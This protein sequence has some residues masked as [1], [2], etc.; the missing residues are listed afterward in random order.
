MPT[1]TR[2]YANPQDWANHPLSNHLENGIH[3]CASS[4]MRAGIRIAYPNYTNLCSIN[5][6]MKKLYPDWN[7]SELQL[8]QFLKLSN[9]LQKN[10]TLFPSDELYGA[11]LSNKKG[12]VM[13][14]RKLAE[15]GVH[16]QDLEKTFQDMLFRGQ[17][18]SS[19]ERIFLTIWKA[20][21]QTIQNTSMNYA[22]YRNRLTSNH[23]T[24]ELLHKA[25]EEIQYSNPKKVNDKTV[26]FLHGF[27]FIT[28]EQQFFLKN[29]AEN[30]N[31]V[32]FLYYE[33]QY[34]RTF[35]FMRS[36][37]QPE[38]GWESIAKSN[39]ISDY[40]ANH[41]SD[42]FLRVYENDRGQFQPGTQEVLAYENF[43]EFMQHV[44][45][46]NY[47]EG[48]LETDNKSF[49]IFTP[50]ASQMNELLEN[51]YP[52]LNLK[53]RNFLSYPVG[54]F[55]STI[56][57]IYKDGEYE[58]SYDQLHELFASGWLYH[59]NLNARNFT[60]DLKN[61]QS[62]VERATTLDEWIRLSEQ[63]KKQISFIDQQFPL[64][65]D[66]SRMQ[67][68]TR[69]P[70]LKNSH[71]SI[72]VDRLNTIIQFLYDIKTI[73][74]ELFESGKDGTKIN[75]HF[76]RLERIMNDRIKRV[77]KS[78]DDVEKKLVQDLRAR[79]SMIQSNTDFLYND[80]YEAV[81]LYLSGKFDQKQEKLIRPFLEIDGEAFKHVAVS[82]NYKVYVGGLDEH[83]FPIA[84]EVFH[85]PLQKDT[86]LALAEHV[87]HIAYDYMRQDAKKYISR[88]LFYIMLRFIPGARLNLS[89]IRYFINQEE[90]KSTLYARQLDLP[91]K[92]YTVLAKEIVDV[93]NH[94]L[95]NLYYTEEELEKGY[96]T[97]LYNDFFAE[98][99]QC[100][101]RFY[102][103][104]LMHEYPVFQQE[105]TQVFLF[106]ELVKISAKNIKFNTDLLYNELDPFFPQ[107]INVKKK[108][109]FETAIKYAYRKQQVQQE[110][111]DNLYVSEVRKNFQFPGLKKADR[112]ALFDETTDKRLHIEEKIMRS[113][114]L[115]FEASSGYHCRFCPHIDICPSVTYG[116]DLKGEKNE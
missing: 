77:E 61:I 41:I 62:Y 68:S 90:R 86:W 49:E 20:L 14:M 98:Y 54:R 93:Q 27:Y 32:M 78:F 111:D 3:I 94:Q 16:P 53:N 21:D 39:M 114:T 116:I 70:F 84:A 91:K 64:T 34:E 107:W 29:L 37:I 101:K 52:E 57:E 1:F 50:N 60:Y 102:Y 51:H 69:S 58:L 28:P 71:F 87:P 74:N 109:E 5:E 97:L 76:K 18:I 105:F 110:I 66:A 100:P 10:K 113:D 81:S 17:H 73:C 24:F 65:S 19:K 115:S 42:L 108:F 79:L 15:S 106:T 30:F 36:F 47:S 31:V 55:F 8:D 11:F 2:T 46:P 38:Y 35:S 82:E 96:S 75:L 89:W 99:V 48:K 44:I 67:K 59:S 88:Y 25:I 40:K 83:A 95:T 43:F 72:E 12:I 92:N 22:D 56:H 80:L 13:H 45:Y 63:L 103:S 23:L 33:P 4:N 6:L 104:Y 7:S 85:W 26:I 9:W 112:N